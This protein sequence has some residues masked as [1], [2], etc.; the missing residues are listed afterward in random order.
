MEVSTARCRCHLR[1]YSP[2][3]EAS[4]SVAMPTPSFA[5]ALLLSLPL[6]NQLGW[7]VTGLDR[8]WCL[9]RLAAAA[10]PGLA[11]PGMATASPQHGPS[12]ALVLPCQPKS[13]PSRHRSP[14]RPSLL[15]GGRREGEKNELEAFSWVQM[16][17]S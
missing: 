13:T 12:L 2:L 8:W 4:N 11:W 6:E 5:C 1:S 14:F 17:S 10:G 15:R 9:P 16:R 3:T 7:R